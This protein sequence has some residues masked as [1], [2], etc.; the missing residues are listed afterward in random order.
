MSRIE[1]PQNAEESTAG[2]TDGFRQVMTARDREAFMSPGRGNRN[3]RIIWGL[4]IFCAVLTIGLAAVWWSSAHPAGFASLIGDLQVLTLAAL[5]ICCVGLISAGI[6]L[7]H[8]D[9]AA[10][11]H[12][13]EADR[14]RKAEASA[15][16]QHRRLS[17]A[18]DALPMGVALYDG[19]ER[20]IAFNAAYNRLIQHIDGLDAS[21]IGHSYEEVL[22]RLEAQLRKVF[23]DRDLSRWKAGYLRRFRERRV[24]DRLWDNGQAMRVGQVPTSSGGLVLTRMDITDL[25]QREEQGQIAQRRFDLL[26]NSLSD[27]VFSTDRTGRF[28]YVGGAML[29]LLGYQPA[30]LLGRQPHDIVH[31]DDRPQLEACIGRLRHERGVPVA[32]THRGLCKDGTIRQIE[33]R[34]TALD[35][36]DNLGGEFAVTGV[37]RDVQAQHDMAERLRYELQ[38]LDSLVQSSGASIVLVD[39]DLRIIMANNGFL[40]TR[41]GRSAEAVIG[42]PLREVIASPIDK[43]IFEAWFAAAPTDVIQA[44]EYENA[45][46][47]HQGRRRIYHVTANPVRNDTGHIQHI[48]FLAVDE[49]ERRAAELQLFDSSRLATVGEMASGVAHE[50]NQPLTIIRFAAESLVEQLQDMAADASLASAGGVIDAKMTRIIAQTERAAAII[51]E[52][53]AFSRRPETTA[54]PFDVAETLR[55]ATQLLREQLRLSR[56]EEVVD[57][58]ESCPPVLGHDS[59][60][61]QV[62][63]NLILN[64]RDAILER[65]AADASQ[66]QPGMVRITARSLPSIGKVVA[67]VEDNG[68]GIPDHV[69]PRLF[70]PFFTTKVAGK[71]TGLGLSVSYQIIRQMG[72]TIVAE[73]RA[74]GGACFTI[75]LDA[76]SADVTAIPSVRVVRSAVA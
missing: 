27:A 20:L 14:A 43:A 56:I 18:F 59:R 2:Q 44:I 61:Q 21:M 10:A 24:I 49:T 25:K 73:N 16:L 7:H 41:P 62:I 51:Q 4:A 57:V 6:L 70:E 35:K 8:A 54:R 38:R 31:P 55:S 65:R 52:L 47:D 64:A 3:V 33:V 9:R 11:E 1:S 5:T 37:M 26:V 17:E 68:P 13:H 28:S 22:T 29:Q 36:A 67:T 23:P 39:R 75:T 74:E 32:Y 42:R 76:A 40:N 66:S 46:M 45:V 69:L 50:I 58:E 34:M 53:K 71:G 19:D 63:I 30:E 48:V 12:R 72:G 60:L 15:L